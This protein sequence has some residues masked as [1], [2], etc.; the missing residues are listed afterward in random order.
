VDEEKSRILTVQLSSSNQEY[1][2][3]FKSKFVK[4]FKYH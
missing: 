1:V 3:D 4:I 2:K